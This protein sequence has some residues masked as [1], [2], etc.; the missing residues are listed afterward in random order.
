M[1]EWIPWLER[2][3]EMDFPWLYRRGSP[4]GQSTKLQYN[5][6]ARRMEC[7][8]PSNETCR[9]VRILA[10]CGSTQHKEHPVMM[11][12]VITVHSSTVV[13]L[14]II[15]INV[16]IKGIYRH[17]Q[18]KR[19]GN[20]STVSNTMNDSIH[21]FI[22]YRTDSGSKTPDSQNNNTA[23]QRRLIPPHHSFTSS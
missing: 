11:I 4:T 12:G 16:Y 7:V 21:S 14:I 9:R 5:E 19:Q 10:D 23:F 2:T 6:N 22:R 3:V 1:K 13:H 15:E 20:Y 17:T 8:T 18:I